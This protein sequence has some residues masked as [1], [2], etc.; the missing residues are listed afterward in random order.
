MVPFRTV[1]SSCES[2]VRCPLI[3]GAT[4]STTAMAPL[5]CHL[6][7][8]LVKSCQEGP[9]AHSVSQGSYYSDRITD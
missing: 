9:E 5:T 3:A 8:E 4:A 6:G 2:T 1:F 7:V